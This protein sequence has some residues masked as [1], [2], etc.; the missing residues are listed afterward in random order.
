MLLWIE[1]KYGTTMSH[2]DDEDEGGGL[3]ETLLCNE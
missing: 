2:D 1:G 3:E